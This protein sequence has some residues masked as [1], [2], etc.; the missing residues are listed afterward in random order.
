M[1]ISLFFLAL[2]FSQMTHAQQSLCV[3]TI[4][5][6]AQSA[7]AI[8]PGSPSAL[9]DTKDALELLGLSNLDFPT[10]AMTSIGNA[11]AFP[12][13]QG[14]GPAIAYNPDFM[15]RLY[16]IESWAPFSV[17]AHEIGHHVASERNH[18]SSHVRELAA[19][20]VSGCAMARAG[21]SLDQA[22]AAV[23]QG[24]PV[25]T[26]SPTHPGTRQRI[27]VIREGYQSC[28]RS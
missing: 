28:R 9:K 5:N 16:A 4:H 1:K 3:F 8:N 22:F 21:A 13:L 23:T 18:P 25:N 11:A 27:Q 14:Q 24:L 15:T 6:N 19:D 12:N 20:R 17:I 10:Y 2:L 26:G 7:N